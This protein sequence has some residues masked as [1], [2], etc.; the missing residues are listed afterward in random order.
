MRDAAAQ[1]TCGADYPTAG[2]GA[3]TDAACN[4]QTTGYHYN[5][6][7]AGSTCAGA[8]C[9]LAGVAGD[10]TACCEETKCTGNAV[11][12]KDHTCAAGSKLKTNAGATAMPPGADP[13]T[14]CC[15]DKEATDCSDAAAFCPTLAGT[16]TDPCISDCATCVGYANLPETTAPNAATSTAGAYAADIAAAAD[17]CGQVRRFC[18]F[19]FSVSSSH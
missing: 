16:S 5:T 14:T 10:M 3:V 15:V 8:F 2:A 12:A 13:E 18:F 11:T 19:F 1:G 7:N 9:D 17:T 4:L 6:A